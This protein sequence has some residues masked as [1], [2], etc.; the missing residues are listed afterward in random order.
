MVAVAVVVVVAVKEEEKLKGKGALDRIGPNHVLFVIITIICVDRQRSSPKWHSSLLPPIM[1]AS[2]SQDRLLE[3]QR[4]YGSTPTK[5]HG[6]NDDEERSSQKSPNPNARVGS[7][8]SSISDTETDPAPKD[9][10]SLK[11]GLSARQVQ[12]IAIAGTIG[13]GLFLGTGRSLAQG[14]P[15]SV[16]ICYSVVGF[17]VYITVLL[18][19]EMATQYP[20]A[21]VSF[22]LISLSAHAKETLG[23]F[24]AY[25]ARFFSPSYAFA[26]SWNYWFNDSV[27]VASDLT[28][29]QLVMSYWTESH[30]WI[31]S[32]VFL[33]FLLGVNAIHVRAYGEMGTP[34]SRCFVSTRSSVVF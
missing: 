7:S 15:A 20:V 31:I 17:V 3:N 8:S 23:S 25:S 11:R 4:L 24:T 10:G 22:S 26:L 32:L 28:A 19:G 1:T 13:T 5:R 18:L 12:M 27:S 14:G 2:A 6:N 33:T 21:G 29:A 16:L 30:L 9:V 34:I